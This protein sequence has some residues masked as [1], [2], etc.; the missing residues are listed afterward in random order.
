MSDLYDIPVRMDYRYAVEQWMGCGE[1][2][3]LK[4][5]NDF[6][7]A[8][9]HAEKM[10]YFYSEISLRVAERWIGKE[11]FCERILMEI[12]PLEKTDWVSNGF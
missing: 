8:V 4:V 11:G 12:L 2:V 3:P 6:D 1:W 10:G 5:Y 7:M 9:N